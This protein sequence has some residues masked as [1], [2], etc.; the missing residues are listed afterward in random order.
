[1]GAPRGALLE[2]WLLNAQQ[3]PRR[4]GAPNGVTAALD[5]DAVEALL[6]DELRRMRMQRD[7]LVKCRALDTDRA[8]SKS[9][10]QLSSML[11]AKENCVVRFCIYCVPTFD[12]PSVSWAWGFDGRRLFVASLSRDASR[13]RGR[14]RRRPPC[15]CIATSTAHWVSCPA[16]PCCPLKRWCASFGVP[17][18][19]TSR[20]P[21]DMEGDAL[22]SVRGR[23]A[24]TWPQGQDGSLTGPVEVG[25]AQVHHDAVDVQRRAHD[26]DVAL[27][28]REHGISCHVYL[29]TFR[30]EAPPLPSSTRP[31]SKGL[32]SWLHRKKTALQSKQQRQ[33]ST[34]LMRDYVK[35]L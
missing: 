34:R 14:R 33:F 16:R 28:W 35:V 11:S 32:L 21:A 13:C 17:A 5:D 23:C 27:P 29:G 4:V 26:G 15:A 3:T 8:L 30:E 20:N 2:Q 18:H 10:A 1:M 25:A 31:K 19:F 12:E 22:G 24:A 7:F 6:R 9:S